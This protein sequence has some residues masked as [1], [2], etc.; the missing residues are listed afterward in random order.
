MKKILWLSRRDIKHPASGGAEVFCDKVMTGMVK[1]GYEITLF[2][3]S[4][5]GASPED[6]IN[7][8]RV[9][10]SGGSFSVFLKGNRFT[11]QHRA[12]Y[13]AIIDEVN[14]IPFFTHRFRDARRKT[15][16][17]VHQLAREIWF[18]QMPFP[19]SLAGYIA[20]PFLLRPYRKINA[21]ITVSE[22]TRHGLTAMGLKNDIFIIREP[23]N[24]P[25]IP[26]ERTQDKFSALTL[27]YLGRIMPSKRVEEIIKTLAVLTP[28]EPNAR[29]IIM[30]GGEKKYTARLKKLADKLGISANI[31]FTGFV[32]DEQK[33]TNLRRS[34]FLMM[35]STREGWGMVVNEANAQGTPAV[36]YDAPGLRDSVKDGV[37]GI[38]CRDNTPAQAAARMIEIYRNRESYTAMVKNSLADAATFSPQKTVDEFEN[39]LIRRM[40]W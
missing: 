14:T 31:E 16:A 23:L 36:V 11:K 35:T 18:Y 10:R 30:G 40:G 13:D 25:L 17:L 28:E 9:V 21:V 39:V 38:I 15:F 26:F 6:T 7:G 32:T 5:P 29:L 20:E 19:V 34:H 2:C 4:F 3:A 8:Y 24:L 1:K 33:S 27:V 22:S 12:G 37:N